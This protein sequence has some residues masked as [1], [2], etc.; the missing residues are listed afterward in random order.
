MNEKK[1]RKYALSTRNWLLCK[2]LIG[3]YLIWNTYQLL[4]GISNYEGT[5][6]M[7]F[8]GFSVVFAVVGAGLIILSIRD[9]LQ[10][11]YVGGPMDTS[12][13]EEEEKENTNQSAP[14]IT[15][16]EEEMPEAARRAAEEREA[17]KAAEE[18]ET[19]TIEESGIETE[20]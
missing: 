20:E 17:A 8:L 1:P 2:V 9:I 4:Q 12:K 14:K 6:K 16:D 3:A 13:K 10:G 5:Q 15:F 19:E 18:A 11:Y 7:L